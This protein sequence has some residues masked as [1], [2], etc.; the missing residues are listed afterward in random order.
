MDLRRTY[1]GANKRRNVTGLGRLN[2]YLFRGTSFSGASPMRR[3]IANSLNRIDRVV[4]SGCGSRLGSICV[5][6]AQ[7]PVTAEAPT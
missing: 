6:V 5:I 2:G 1:W 3:G 4:L 7:R